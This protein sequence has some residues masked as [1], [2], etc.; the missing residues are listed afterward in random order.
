MNAEV[1]RKY[2]L[3]TYS[4]S[5]KNLNE[6]SMAAVIIKITKQ[7]ETNIVIGASVHSFHL[8]YNVW[9][10]EKKQGYSVQTT[11]LYLL[12]KKKKKK[13]PHSEGIICDR[14]SLEDG[15]VI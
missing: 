13:G 1:Y 4:I 14:D 5:Y 15:T 6:N 12:K 11:L 7:K 3:R 10:Y 2:Q 9:E 8:H